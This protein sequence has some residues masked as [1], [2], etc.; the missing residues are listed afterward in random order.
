LKGI[1]VVSVIVS[2][3]ILGVLG[4]APGAAAVPITFEFTGEVTQVFN[5]IGG[6]VPPEISAIINV[7]DPISGSYTFDSLAPD[8]VA[9]DPN[10]GSYPIDDFLFTVN[11]VTYGTSAGQGNEIIIKNLQSIDNYQVAA[12]GIQQQ[13]GSGAPVPNKILI[14][15]SDFDSTALVSDSLLLNP[16]ALILFENKVFS[17]LF[18]N[19]IVNG[20]ITSLT[21]APESDTDGDGFS[22][23]GGDCDDGNSAINPDAIEIE[24]G[25]DDNCDGVID[26]GFDVDGDGFSPAGGDCDDTN[27]TVFPGAAE[28]LDGIDN[29]CNGQVDDI[30][31]LTDI[32]DEVQNIEKKLD[33]EIESLITQIVDTLTSIVTD[34]GT[35][36]G[37]LQD[38][39]SGIGA[40]KSD[41]EMIKS[42]IEMLKDQF[43]ILD[44]KL[45][46]LLKDDFS[47]ESCVDFQE[48][49]DK[50]TA[51]GKE[52][53]LKFEKKLALCNELFP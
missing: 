44:K 35:I 37:I 3:L 38:E 19:T 36:L 47:E 8:T 32:S 46:I 13:L 43:S 45:D 11:F 33:G 12:S 9:A 52:I 41:T 39:N 15:L 48:E 50:I 4:S 42:D 20:V 7:G 26:E 34:I 24:N 2:I 16:P 14:G 27:N 51:K 53:P 1:W 17:M 23:P 6:V 5:V 28:I 49:A 31:I 22:P 40:I 29:N 10:R 18:D 21:L 30:G 25:I